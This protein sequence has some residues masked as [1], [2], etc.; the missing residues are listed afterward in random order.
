MLIVSDTSPISNL[1]LIGQI[2]LLREIYPAITVPSAV[3]QELLVSRK[4][5]ITSVLTPDWVEI[6]QVSDRHLLKLL[7]AELD[8]GEAEAI[9]LALELEAGVLLIDE[10]KGRQ[11][12]R[13]LGMPIMGL[14]V[15]CF[16]PRDWG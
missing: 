15:Y 7:L 11:K 14:Q 2:S 4:F 13:I 9:A 6:K 3:Y 1:L 10:R 5:D 16:Q 12:A 8:A